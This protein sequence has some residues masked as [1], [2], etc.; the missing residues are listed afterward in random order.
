LRLLGARLC[1]RYFLRILRVY[2]LLD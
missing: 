1:A 2:F